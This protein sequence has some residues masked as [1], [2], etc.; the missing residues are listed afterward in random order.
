[1]LLD[2]SSE[3]VPRDAHLGKWFLASGAVGIMTALLLAV[4]LGHDA[5]S[6]GVPSAPSSVKAL[7]CAPTAGAA[8]RGLDRRLRCGC[9]LVMRSMSAPLFL[10]EPSA[11]R[12]HHP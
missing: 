1:M 9:W 2:Q 8:L 6:T 12:R 4:G 5:V 3:N 11:E 10:K 7:R